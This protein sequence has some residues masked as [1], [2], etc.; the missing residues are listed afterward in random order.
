MV[1]DVNRN[2]RRW[3]SDSGRVCVIE[4]WHPSDPSEVGYNLLVDGEWVGTFGTLEDATNSVGA[5]A[6]A[7]RG[8][9]VLRP[10]TEAP[11]LGGKPVRA[12]LHLAPPLSDQD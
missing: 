8:T 7:R 10:Q 6:A 11:T 1:S 4:G 2:P 12:D 9:V 3:V 5:R